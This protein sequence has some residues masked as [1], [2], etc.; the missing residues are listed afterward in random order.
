MRFLSKNNILISTTSILTLLLAIYWIL[1]LWIPTENIPEWLWNPNLIITLLTVWLYSL[2]NTFTCIWQKQSN[3]L[4]E[5]IH[6]FSLLGVLWSIANHFNLLSIHQMGEIAD[7][8]DHLVIFIVLYLTFCRTLLQSKHNRISNV[9]RIMSLVSMSIFM[10][11]TVATLLISYDP[12]NW[13][14]TNTWY[15]ALVA[16]ITTLFLTPLLHFISTKKGA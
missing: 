3:T 14:L 6:G 15:S 4:L 13:I 7:N 16:S 2:L 5:L 1:M 9:F 8:I 11:V 12:N 10:G